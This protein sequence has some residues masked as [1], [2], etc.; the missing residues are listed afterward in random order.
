MISAYG[1][2][3]A[4]LLAGS[5]ALAVMV[6]T[7]L[8]AAQEYPL[9]SPL[10]V[11]PL[12]IATPKLLHAPL[13]SPKPIASKPVARKTPKTFAIPALVLATPTPAIAAGLAEAGPA[14]SRAADAIL[15]GRTK[16]APVAA[17]EGLALKDIKPAARKPPSSAEQFCASISESVAESRLAAQTARLAEMESQLRQRIA[18]LEQRRTEVKQMLERQKDIEK[19]ADESVVAILSR[20]RPEAAAA[21]LSAA[22]ETTAAAVLA[23]L[24]P[25]TASA[26][27]N[28]ID[29][30]KA[31]K[32]TDAIARTRMVQ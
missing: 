2:K 17:G 15:E 27:L 19:K 29:A 22:D 10:D 8:A 30:A 16:D 31:A 14:N 26:I 3:S 6:Q 21:Q 23:K 7:S 32:L 24:N 25:R 28:E 13:R 9:P 18:E 12:D 5:L 11:P 1:W 4:K 20:M